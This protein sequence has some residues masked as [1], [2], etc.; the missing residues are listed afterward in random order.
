MVKICSYCGCEN[1]ESFNF[2]SNCGRPLILKEEKNLIIDYKKLIIISY[3]VTII[4]SWGGLFFNLLFN[5]Y[6]FF[7]I[8]GL[9]L[10]FYLIQSQNKSVKKHGY[11]Q[12]ALSLIGIFSSIIL[13]FYI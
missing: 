4:F 5:S 10:P 6:G 11:I 13:I 8:I 2:C 1:Q 3:V 7:G 9:F 12:I